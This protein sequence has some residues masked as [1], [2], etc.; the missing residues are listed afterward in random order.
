VEFWLRRSGRSRPF[1]IQSSRLLIKS[2]S[3]VLA[4]FRSS[5]YPTRRIRCLGSVGWAGEK[6]SLPALHS[7]RPCW[8]AFLNSLRGLMKE[9]M[10]SEHSCFRCAQVARA[11]RGRGLPSLGLMAR[12]GVPVGGRVRRLCAV[13]DQSAPI[14]KEISSKL[15]GS[16]YII[17]RAESRIDRTTL[18]KNRGI[19]MARAVGIIPPTPHGDDDDL[20]PCLQPWTG[21]RSQSAG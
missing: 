1:S 11:T 15:G 9:P 5:T 13:E 8:T 7:L 18:E 2:A 14:P 20:Y 16:I 21:G 17:R 19:G 3:I 4:S 6:C 10:K 12:L